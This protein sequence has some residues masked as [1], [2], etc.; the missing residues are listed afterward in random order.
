MKVVTT[1]NI[2]KLYGV[3]RQRV[4]QWRDAGLPYYQTDKFFYYDLDKV[5]RWVSER[6]E[7]YKSWNEAYIKDRFHK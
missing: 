7:R 2:C 3:S 6:K 4:H 1:S 5:E